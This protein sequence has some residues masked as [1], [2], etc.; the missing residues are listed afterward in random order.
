[1]WVFGIVDVTQQ[2]ALGYMEIVPR[3]DAATLLP[4]V[5]QHVLPGT[6][7]HS[8]EW[9]AYNRINTLP[10]VAAHRT[11][12]HS[13]NFV[14]PG[15]GVHTQHIESYWNQVKTKL[16][17]ER[18]PSPYAA[19]IL[20]SIH[21]AGTSWRNS[22]GSL[23]CRHV[24]YQPVVSSDLARCLSTS[25]SQS[26]QLLVSAEVLAHFDP[27]Q[28]SIVTC[29]ASLYGLGAVLAQRRKDGK[30][31]PVAFALR[32]LTKVERNYAQVERES[33]AVIFILQKKIS[34][35]SVW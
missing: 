29:D 3:R 33:L 17:N 19:V 30:E 24:G 26:K 12:N 13:L 5:A 35:I 15:T 16:K 10:L 32:T 4:I 22:R 14:D 23:C 31:H 7:V 9:R 2:P 27:Q 11:V 25:S 8:D 1:M 21:V 28:E 6:I 20:G 18:V 34:S